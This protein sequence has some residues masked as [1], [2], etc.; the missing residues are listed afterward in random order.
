MN[1]F[2]LILR[3][4]EHTSKHPPLQRNASTA[5]IAGETGLTPSVKKG[6]LSSCG[7]L[8]TPNESL[9]SFFDENC[10]IDPHM[11]L[12]KNVPPRSLTSYNSMASLPQSKRCIDSKFELSKFHQAEELS[13]CSKI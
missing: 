8:V 13:E 5:N 2:E 11:E 1:P 6:P 10:E 12:E 9:T 7:E 3:E 4:C